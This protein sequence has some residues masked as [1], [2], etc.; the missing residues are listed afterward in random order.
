LL[1]REKAPC[2]LYKLL[3]DMWSVPEL[4]D[5]LSFILCNVAEWGGSHSQIINFQSQP[6]CFNSFVVSFQTDPKVPE[7]N[8]HAYLIKLGFIPRLIEALIDN[9]EVVSQNV[10]GVFHFLNTHGILQ[11]IIHSHTHTHTHTHNHTFSFPNKQT[12]L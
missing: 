11:T 8:N 4:R 12:Q 2:G 1:T 6:I 3:L 7:W 10:T 9:N 5:R